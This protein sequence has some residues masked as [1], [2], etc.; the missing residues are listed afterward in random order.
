VR[1]LTLRDVEV[2][3][4]A[5]AE[6]AATQVWREVLRPLAAE[7]RGEARG[8]AAWM[9]RE[10]QG[11]LRALM[12]DAEAL[13]EN[14]A[15]AEAAILAVA[16]GIERGADPRAVELP[17]STIAFVRTGVRR[18]VPL[19]LLLRNFRIGH[20]L[21]WQ[22]FFD[23]IVARNDDAQSQAAATSLM[24]QWT[25]AFVDAGVTRAEQTYEVERERW[26]RSAHASRGE[27][28]TAIL[29]GTE[30]DIRRASRRLRYELARAHIGIAAAVEKA[31]E[32]SDPQSLLAE[33][34]SA[35][36]A[37]V[38]ADQPLVLP[39]GVSACMA[40]ISRSRRFSDDDVVAL[41]RQPAPGVRVAI[42]EP[43]TG[44]DGF[45][46]TQIDA[47]HARRVASEGKL[48]GPVRYA[49]VAVVAMATADAEQAA[50]FV[51]RILGPL[52]GE[53]EVTRRA[54]ETLAVYLSENRSRSRAAARLYVHV[55][56]VS[57]RVRQAEEILGRSIESA[58]LDLQV[59]LALLPAVRGARRT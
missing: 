18:N 5:V 53:D 9:V 32:D 36:A 39:S 27:A 2:E 3:W 49:D 8:L 22:W 23:H 10:M 48:T 42:G 51:A 6:P 35:L 57:Y 20:E 56:T 16:Q 7:L 43:G 24:S 52:A 15:S 45:R 28:I 31:D 44:I 41:T 38:S 19:P 46:H 59:A 37:T 40:W 34:V 21:V 54:A 33:T 55:N 14:T 1:G 30:G 4:A 11:H 29:A 17:A 50:R 26:L 13:A 47:G 58:P 12:P 25:F